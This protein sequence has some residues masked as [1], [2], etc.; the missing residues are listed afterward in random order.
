MIIYRGKRFAVVKNNY[1]LQNNEINMTSSSSGK[2]AVLLVNLGS[3]DAPTR[4]ALRRYLREFLLDRRVIDLPRW[5]WWPILFG[6][7]LNTRPQKS[8][9]AYASI[10]WPEGA[11]LL[12]ITARQ[13]EKLRARFAAQGLGHITIDYAMRYGNPA[14]G[15]RLAALAQAGVE[16][17]LVL[18]MYPQY[19]DPTTA[20]VFDGVAKALE[21]QRFI[22]E[23]RFIRDWYAHPRYIA[24]LADS[25]RAHIAKHGEADKFLIS[26]HG[27]PLRYID[28]GDG[29]LRQC[30]E[31]VRL[32]AEA[33]GWDTSR[34]VLAFQSRF[35]KEEWIQPYADEELVRLAR[36]G[37]GH[38]SVMC[39]GFSADCLETLEEMAVANRELFLAQGGARYDYIPAL[40]DQ[41]DHIAL[42][43]DLLQQHGQGWAD[44]SAQ[45]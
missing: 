45:A 31:T 20:S 40:N 25:V 18:P 38:V 2:T 11:P 28:E 12:V 27:E 13:V 36:S 35:G 42:L 6:I 30:Q 3:P 39:P 22:P 43:A 19:A 33:L 8:A 14:I 21:K 17:L 1:I 9:H 26:F 7:V 29:Y 32:L 37:V 5:Q 24:A 4:P 23:V 15:E 16:R 44:F 34:Y 10:W 41:D